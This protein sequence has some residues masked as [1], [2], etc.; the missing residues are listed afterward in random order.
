MKGII[1]R[2]LCAEYTN[3]PENS[4]VGKTV[5]VITTIPPETRIRLNG[6]V[7]VTNNYETYLVS[8]IHRT[9]NRETGE[10]TKTELVVM[11]DGK[12]F[13]GTD[14]V[15]KEEIEFINAD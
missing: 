8:G 4:T 2:D 13:V 15:T 6:K 11:F 12:F 7:F 10:I 14:L 3:K 1:I 9:I 5:D